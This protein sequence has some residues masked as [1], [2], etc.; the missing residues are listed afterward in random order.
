VT[1]K[2]GVI[3]RAEDRGLG[4][5]TWEVVRHLHPERVLVI[6]MGELGRGFPQ[7][8]E[9]YPTGTLAP[10]R[11]GALPERLVREWL[12]GLDVVYSAETFYDQ[13]MVGWATLAGVATV[14]HVMPE[15]LFPDQPRP[16]RVWLPTPWR[17]ELVGPHQLVPVPVALDRW[18]GSEPRAEV[19][20]PL[21][22][23][24]VAGHKAAADRN[25]TTAFLRALSLTHSRVDA[26]MVDQDERTWGKR[27]IAPYTT[28]KVEGPTRNYWDTYLDTD[29]LVMPRRYGGLC[30]PVQEAAGAGLAVA[31]SAVPPNAWYPAA[32]F[33]TQMTG[34]LET[35]GGRLQIG[36]PNATHVAR[37]I[38]TLARSRAD[39]EQLKER[40]RR[41]AA[42]HSWATLRPYWT[43]Q[44]EAAAG[45]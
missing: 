25:G 40:S 22:V 12:E 27:P 39:L 10:W 19:D 17:A 32:L 2:V 35:P 43:T 1:L 15:F 11:N 9:R 7:H 29:L 41:W 6:D 24:H 26:R 13:R 33:R 8:L 21:R 3:A 34:R 36:T 45:L 20:G 38:D 28:L 42:D 16:T 4:I 23:L 44:L 30:L 5:L 31:M 37:M 14:L 18:W